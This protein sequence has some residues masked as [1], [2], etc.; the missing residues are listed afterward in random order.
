MARQPARDR[1]AARNRARSK[2]AFA[3]FGT[4]CSERCGAAYRNGGAD[5]FPRYAFRERHW[6]LKV[7]RHQRRNRKTVRSISTHRTNERAPCGTKL[8]NTTTTVLASQNKTRERS[9]LRRGASGAGQRL[10]TNSSSEVPHLPLSG[11]A[12]ATTVAL[13]HTKRLYIAA[14]R[15]WDNGEGFTPYT[16]DVI[17]EPVRYRDA[18]PTTEA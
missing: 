9:R 3:L 6:H 2:R 11:C 16:L 7:L 17:I 18:Q 1:A 4:L 15:G 10:P 12:I 8:E 5:A 13:Q 14:C